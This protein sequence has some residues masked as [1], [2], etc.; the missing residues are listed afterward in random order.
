MAQCAG[1]AHFVC[2]YG[3]LMV[4]GTFSMTKVNKRAMGS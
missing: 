3:L 2:N 4:N 1:Y